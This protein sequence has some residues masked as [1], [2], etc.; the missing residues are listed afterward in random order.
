MSEALKTDTTKVPL[1]RAVRV[2]D[3]MKLTAKQKEPFLPPKNLTFRM[4]P[5]VYRVRSIN[6]DKLRF[7]V[8]LHDVVVEDG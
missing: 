6:A 7:N 5:Y 2:S 3:L 8:V 4:G 1:K